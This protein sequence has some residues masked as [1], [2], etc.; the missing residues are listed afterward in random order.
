MNLTEIFKS[1]SSFVSTNYL[2]IMLGLVV[3]MLA[4]VVLCC[5]V[6]SKLTK[7]RKSVSNI[8]KT[9]ADQIDNFKSEL[10]ST[11]KLLSDTDKSLTEAET[12]I[13]VLEN[14]KEEANKRI[15]N[16]TN[17][18]DSL[19]EST[20]EYEERIS[21]L[22]LTNKELSDN[23]NKLT[24]EVKAAKAA[25]ST[26]ES[27]YSSDLNQL[28]EEKG[29]LVEEH[30]KFAA[31][32]VAKIEALKQELTKEKE[33]NSALTV[34]VKQISKDE[35]S[36]DKKVTVKKRV[37]LSKKFEEMNRD[38]LILS[39]RNLGLTNYSKM[40][41]EDLVNALKAKIEKRK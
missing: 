5:V 19:V 1:V 36:Q 33:V 37:T 25:L 13:Q 3:V 30:S 27:K 10:D 4:L 6:K 11:H 24:S 16:L 35:T 22:T 17:V 34:A 12:K 41:K 39:A 8:L 26:A 28:I 14:E 9:T 15:E 21:K 32:Q 31:E 23:I 18:N 2:W 29:L 7:E 40:K 20:N 38:E